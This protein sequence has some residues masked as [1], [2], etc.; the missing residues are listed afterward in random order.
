MT[1][2]EIERAVEVVRKSVKVFQ[3]VSLYS[4]SEDYNI[5]VMHNK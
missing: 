1:I 4:V 2:H 5:I 3:Q